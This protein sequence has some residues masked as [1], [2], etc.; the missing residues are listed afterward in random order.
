MSDTRL[1]KAVEQGGAV[2]VED[3]NV[4]SVRRTR[5]ARGGIIGTLTP[6]VFHS[7][8]DQAKL[9]PFGTFKPLRY[10]WSGSKLERSKPLQASIRTFV[11]THSKKASRSLLGCVLHAHADKKEAAILRRTSEWFY[12]DQVWEANTGTV[13]GMNW[14]G[15]ALGGRVDRS[16]RSLDGFDEPIYRLQAVRRMQKARAR[17]SERAY[18]EVYALIVSEHG[19]K[20]F[21]ATFAYTETEAER[22][23]IDLLRRLSWLYEKELS[24]PSTATGTLDE[25]A[26]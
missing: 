17:F 19:R 18:N 11:E 20:H 7:L 2:Y 24:P 14:Q 6:G 4:F 10:V 22:R 26:S 21:A 16:G 23:A 15:L 8:V 12:Q 9:K 5:D 13:A 1:I 25:A 3:K